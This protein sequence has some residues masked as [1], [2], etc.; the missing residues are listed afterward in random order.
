MM[1]RATYQFCSY[2]K[3]KFLPENHAD[4]NL[5]EILSYIFAALGFYLQFKH[6]FTL[7]FP[8]NLILWPFEVAEY[9]I[10]WTITT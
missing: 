2:H 9:Y 4:S 8:L 5:D 1:A 10:R 3:M 7:P 6:K